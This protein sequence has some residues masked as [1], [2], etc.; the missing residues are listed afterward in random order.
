M[1]ED[2]FFSRVRFGTNNQNSIRTIEIIC[3]HEWSV[4]EVEGLL[5]AGAKM[6]T[7]LSSTRVTDTSFTPVV[8][9]LGEKKSSPEIKLLSAIIW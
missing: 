3:V 7:S 4:E 5:S 9:G 1:L 8:C 6:P 2:P